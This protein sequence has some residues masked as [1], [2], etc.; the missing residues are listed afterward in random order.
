MLNLQRAIANKGPVAIAAEFD[1]DLFF[2]RIY[3]DFSPSSV[4]EVRYQFQKSMESQGGPQ[5]RTYIDPKSLIRQINSNTERGGSYQFLGF[6]RKIYIEEERTV[7]V[8]RMIRPDG[9]GI[10]YHDYVLGPGN[11]N[12]VDVYSYLSGEDVTRSLR[13][14]FIMQYREPP[15]LIESGAD[16]QYWKARAEINA[17][18]QAFSRKQFSEVLNTWQPARPG[19][20]VDPTMPYSPPPGGEGMFDKDAYVTAYGAFPLNY[21]VIDSKTGGPRQGENPARD[22]DGMDGFLMLKDFDRALQCVDR[23]QACVGFD[24]PYLNVIRAG[25]D[26]AAGKPRDAKTRSSQA[27]MFAHQDERH[28]G[29]KPARNDA[30]WMLMNSMAAEAAYATPERKQRT[31]EETAGTLKSIKNIDIERLKYLGRFPD[32]QEFANSRA[33]ED[34]T[35]DR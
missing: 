10:N 26:L 31:F 13:R 30:L 27:L 29:G 15:P 4:P 14:D 33:F 32:F 28:G 12:V 23:L 2:K 1:W 6:L 5:N 7:A 11:R 34:L 17:M 24:D 20:S 35:R 16:Y 3:R 21:Q 25:I 22:L 19:S 18:V 8:F 9:N